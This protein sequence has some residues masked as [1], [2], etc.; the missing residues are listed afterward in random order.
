MFEDSLY[1]MRGAQRLA[2]LRSALASIDVDEDEAALC[3]KMTAEASAVPVSAPSITVT[4]VSSDGGG[5]EKRN[6]NTNVWFAKRVTLPETS[7]PLTVSVDINGGA[8]A[9]LAMY[10]DGEY[11]VLIDWTRGSASQN[12]VQ[13]G[14]GQREIDISALCAAQGIES[15]SGKEVTFVF[16]VRD[17]ANDDNGTGQDINIAYFRIG[18]AGKETAE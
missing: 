1:A 3:A 15:L 12:P 17:N 2:Q 9:K 7:D 6:A 16:E 13:E 5:N 11:V 18:W 8:K 4:S 14:I 10:V